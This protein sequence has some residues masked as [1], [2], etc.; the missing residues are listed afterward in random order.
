MEKRN[1]RVAKWIGTTPAIGFCTCCAATFK[2]PLDS[3]KRTT[4]AQESLRKQ[5]DTHKCNPPNGPESTPGSNPE[6]NKDK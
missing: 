3:L 4:D 2:V 5:F 1:L 6:S